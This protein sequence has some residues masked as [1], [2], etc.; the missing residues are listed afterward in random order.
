MGANSSHWLIKSSTT[1]LIC[2]LLWWR[3][4]NEISISQEWNALI[5]VVIWHH[6]NP[7]SQFTDLREISQANCSRCEWKI[8]MKFWNYY[9]KIDIICPHSVQLSYTYC[10]YPKVCGLKNTNHSGLLDC[11]IS[12]STFACAWSQFSM[13]WMS[14]LHLGQWLLLTVLL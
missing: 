1:L 4:A 13:V 5:F 8:F 6:S 12:F 9:P 3:D 10:Y 7:L 2:I 11:L 14:K